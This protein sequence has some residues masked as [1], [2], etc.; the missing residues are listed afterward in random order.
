[1]AVKK[2]ESI[3][4]LPYSAMM[5]LERYPKTLILL[6]LQL[7]ILQLEHQEL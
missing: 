7:R 3:T 2:C 6:N 4:R 5:F 1:M